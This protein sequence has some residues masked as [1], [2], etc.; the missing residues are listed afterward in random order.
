MSDEA[1]FD[2][3][4]YVNKQNCRFWGSENPRATHQHQLHPSSVW[5]G[6]MA[7]R[8]IGPYFFQN[9]DGT[10]ETISETSYITMIENFLMPMAEQNPLKI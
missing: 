4:D 8:V 6:V 7:N 2:L 3:N 9:E 10:P 1:H 5:G